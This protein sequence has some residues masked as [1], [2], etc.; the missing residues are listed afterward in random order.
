[1]FERFKITTFA[2]W[3]EHLAALLAHLRERKQFT[4]YFYVKLSLLFIGINVAC[5]WIAMLTAFPEIVV[6]PRSVHYFWLQFPVGILGAAFDTLSLFITVFMVERA[7]AS[8]TNASYLC[9]L[10][11]DVG[12]AVVATFWVLFVF[13]ASGWLISLFESQP[14]S[15]LARHSAYQNLLVQTLQDPTGQQ[16]LRNIYFG[17]IMGLSASLPTFIHVYCSLKAVARTIHSVPSILTNRV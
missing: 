8:T 6:G 15:L 10:L 5:Y 16:E 2:L 12:I 1:M 14:V 13:S 4:R 7:L 3:R 11:V 9:H 17:I